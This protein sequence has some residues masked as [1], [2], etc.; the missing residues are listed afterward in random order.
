M[1]YQLLFIIVLVTND[2]ISQELLLNSSFEQFDSIAYK[3]DCFYAKYWTIPNNSTVDYYSV[4]QTLNNH[5]RAI[6]NNI[7]GYHPAFDGK[8]YIGLGIFGWQ[9]C[10][11]ELI[12]GTLKRNLK[13]D[14]L[15]QISFHIKYAGDSVWLYSKIIEA[16]FSKDKYAFGMNTVYYNETYDEMLKLIKITF[17]IEN[18]YKTGDWIKCSAVYKAKGWEK[19]IT[20]GLIPQGKRLQ[21]DCER[22]YKIWEES[23]SIAEVEKFIIKNEIYPIGVNRNYKKVKRAMEKWRDYSYYFIDD[24]SV[25]QIKEG[26]KDF[27]YP[28]NK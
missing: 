10:D 24:V 21:P 14:S 28:F 4:Y 20:L 25:T 7:F 12:T 5:F 19:F 18:A 17:N 15:Y 6:P 3:N 26:E 11:Y 8:A 16:Y 27:T 1:K 9:A 23:N 22:Y 2:I 13:K